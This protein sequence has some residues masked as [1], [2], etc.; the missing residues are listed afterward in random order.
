M[1]ETIENIR[2]KIRHSTAH[3]MAEAVTNLFPGTKIG[4]GPPTENVFYYDFD[5]PKSL[6]QEDF[7]IIEKEMK[8]IIKAKTKFSELWYLEKKRKKDLLGKIIK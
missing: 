5:C 2:Y 7:K 4:M 8:R 1:E 6:S 3:I